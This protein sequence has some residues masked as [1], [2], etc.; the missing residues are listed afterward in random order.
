MHLSISSSSYAV[1]TP[2]F[3]LAILFVLM[4]ECTKYNEHEW[5]LLCTGQQVICTYSKRD[6]MNSLK[7][8]HKHEH[9]RFSIHSCEYV[10][11]FS[12]PKIYYK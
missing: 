9:F 3:S 1:K 4:W 8:R 7:D 12:L 6:S 2:S 5:K 11:S 10:I